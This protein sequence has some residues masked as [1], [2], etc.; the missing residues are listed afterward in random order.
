MTRFTRN[1]KF[2]ADTQQPMDMPNLTSDHTDNTDL[3]GPKSSLEPF[4]N[5]SAGL[6]QQAKIGPLKNP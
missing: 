6:C 1:E 5:F 2:V 3:R 4:L